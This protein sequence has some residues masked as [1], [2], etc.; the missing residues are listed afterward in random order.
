[1]KAG[2]GGPVPQHPKLSDSV[3]HPVNDTTSDHQQARAAS[4]VFDEL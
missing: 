2:N 3:I 4:L 1:V